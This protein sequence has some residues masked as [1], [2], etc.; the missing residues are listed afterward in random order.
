MTVSAAI[1]DTITQIITPKD[2]KEKIAAGNLG[3]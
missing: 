1:S 3:V 2:N